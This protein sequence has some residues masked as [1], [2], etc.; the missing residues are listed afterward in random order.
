M[1]CFSMLQNVLASW[2]KAN[3]KENDI[4]WVLAQD[5]LP[6]RERFSSN[7]RRLRA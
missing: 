6:Y 3:P 1:L 4:F 7:E 5:L 2:S